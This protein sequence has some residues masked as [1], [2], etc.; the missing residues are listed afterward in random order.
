M[1]DVIA[2]M[3]LESQDFD[4]KLK[5]ATANL[6]HMEREVRRTGATFEYADK[7]ELE[8]LQSLGQM[9][10]K[11]IDSSGKLKELTKS[12]TELSI[13]YKNMTEEEKKSA[14]GQ[15]LAGSIDQIKGRIGEL[16][17]QIGDVG[18]ELNGSVGFIDKFADALGQLGPAG[19]MAGKLLKGVFGPV[20]IAIAA[21]VGVVHQL[22]EAF[23]RNENAMASAE[24]AAAPFKAIWQQIQRLFDKL[25]PYIADGMEKIANVMS[26][27]FN[28]FT[29]WIEKLG[30]TALGKKLGLDKVAEQMR[31]VTAAQNELTESNKRIADSENAL[32]KLRRSATVN[33]ARDEKEIAKLREQASERDKHTAAERVAMLEKAAQLEEQIMQRNL[34][35]KRKELEVIKL[36]NSLT[37]SGTEDLQAQAD[38]EAAVLQ[39]ETNFYNKKRALQR[40]L[41]AARN[42][43]A[44]DQA[45]GGD[46][47]ASNVKD[48]AAM[49]GEYTKKLEETKARLAEFKAMVEDMNLSQDQRDWAAGMADSYQQQLDKMTGATEEAANNISKS[50]D[51]IPTKFEMIQQSLD[52][53]STGVGAISTLGNSFNEL[54]SIGDDLASAFSGEMDAWDALMTVFNSGI[55]IMQTVIGVMEAINTLQALS[56]ELSKKKV[57]DQATETAAVVGGKMAES[58]ANIQEAG[59]SMLSAGANTAESSSAAG[60]AVANIPIVGPILAVA[61]IAAVLGA[62][63]AAMSKAKNAGSFAGGGMILGNSYSGDNLTANVNSGELILNRAQQGSIAGQLQNNPLGNLQLTSKVRGSD[64]LIVLDNTNSSRGGQRGMYVNVR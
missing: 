36:K 11:A 59:T 18:N 61:A 19:Q 57:T 62:S 5:S 47:G 20:G 58:Q 46:A 15:A 53:M 54:K 3:R 29:G 50:L 28:K 55:G 56:S 44:K 37:Q 10:T 21:V 38:A 30:N 34:D 23:K 48:A 42:E 24:R 45:G 39:E 32:N 27:V 17:G 35:V 9:Q 51:K 6:Q 1:S 43:D 41:Q 33:N 16:K 40:Q 31:N 13:V 52:K 4:N 14:P 60:K 64:L 12:F 63:L 49:W 8:F 22:V 2:R 7:E 25:V 26:G